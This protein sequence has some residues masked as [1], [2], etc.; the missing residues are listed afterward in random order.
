MSVN[1]TSIGLAL[2][3]ALGAYGPALGQDAAP[4]ATLQLLHASD[5]EGNAGAVKNAPNFAAIVEALR[6]Q[7]EATLVISAGDNFIPSPFSNAAGAQDEE[8]RAKLSAALDAAMKTAGIDASGLE[9]GTGRYDIA[10]M[11]II[12]FDASALGNH[13]FDFGPETLVSIIGKSDTWTGALFPLLSANLE[14]GADSPLAAIHSDAGDAGD[15]IVAPYTVLEAGGETYGII[16]ATTPLLATISSPGPGITTTPTSDDMAALAAVIQPVVDKLTADGVNKIILT[17]HLQQIS[18][19]E[20]LSTLLDGVDIF[21]AGGSDTRL[22]NEN[23]RLREKDEAL[24]PYP[25]LGKDAG[26]NDVAIV[27][28]DGQY[29]YVGRLVVG[30]DADGKLLPAT[31]DPEVSGAYA[32]DDEG[33]LA[34]TGAAD[35]AA[36]LA[37]SK[38]GAAVH[39]LVTAISDAV[40][41]TSGSTYFADLAV[42]L[43]G[44][45]EPGV[46]TEE[47]NLGNLTAD[48]NLA[49][50]NELSGDKVLV[51]LKNG[52]GI[53]ASIPLGNGKISELQI[54]DALAFNNPL[55]LVT[56][57]PEQLVATLEY[58]VAAST[59]EDDGTPTNAQ[60]RFPQ[61][62][63]MSFAFDPTEEAGSRV[64]EVT[65][66]GA[67][68]DGSDVTIYADGELTP[69][70]AEFEDGIRA[71][72]LS[73]LLDGGDGYPY[74]SFV[75]ENAGFADVVDL[76][77][78][79]VIAAGAAQFTNVGTEQDALA[80]YLATF[81]AP[82]DLPDTS[83]IE[84][85][86][87]RN[88]LFVQ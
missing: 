47:T 41:T 65:L 81:T 16:G 14:V 13:E 71:V 62:G 26:G 2:C 66:L 86:R 54:Q 37:G 50:A 79:D 12:G 88:T 59:Y 7:Q 58:G 77:K 60:G 52:G 64:M 10:I 73:F 49:V 23:L 78:P 84:D 74:P 85:T 75:E 4:A 11:N 27:S 69:A 1:R 72:T 29:T 33:V 9:T 55:S 30:F 82:V 25:I 80:E 18:L 51:S 20:K 35:L 67:A 6:P 38:A 39:D 83:G 15:G 63:G 46:R 34:V 21:I 42:D 32:T 3:A 70:S 53:R 68:A 40:L 17:S 36:A 22:A 48:A 19:E 24:G 28:T 31:I 87:I 43:N 56:L 57:T 76:M 5:L 45:R 44:N 8:V 61:V